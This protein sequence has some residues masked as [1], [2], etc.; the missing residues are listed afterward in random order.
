MLKHKNYKMFAAV[1][2]LIFLLITV[3]SFGK[4]NPG[5]GG[6]DSGTRNSFSGSRSGESHNVSGSF[7]SAPTRSDSMRGSSF[8]QGQSSNSQSSAF[9]R[10][11]SSISHQR[12]TSAPSRTFSSQNRQFSRDTNF[13]GSRDFHNRTSSNSS[14]SQTSRGTVSSP[15]LRPWQAAGTVKDSLRANNS[16]H[17]D[18]RRDFFA[19][20]GFR[21]NVR[22]FD[23]RHR[24]GHGFD[25]RHDFHH[26]HSFFSASILIGWPFFS[27]Y[28]WPYDNGYWPG[29]YGG[30]GYSPSNYQSSY[31]T[32]APSF[33]YP[34]RY[35]FVSLN[36]FWP[37][38]NYARYYDYGTYPYF[39]Y[40]TVSSP[41]KPGVAYPPTGSDY[42]NK[43]LYTYTQPFAYVSQ[44]E[45]KTAADYYFEQG[46]NAFAAGDYRKAVVNFYQ[47]KNS[48]PDDV[49]LPFAY[50]QAL[51]ADGNYSKAAQQLRA[52]LE[53]QPAGS[54]WAFYPRGLY[55][56]D[57][58]LISQIN[59]L[60]SQT[61]LDTNLQLLLGYQLL[62]IQKL[63]EAQG[64]LSNASQDKYNNVAAGKLLIVLDNLKTK[65]T[66]A[67]PNASQYYTALD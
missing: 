31:D 28:C 5:R 43:N 21:G 66:P 40:I 64:Y 19:R 53:K 65:T 48:S 13:N 3:S 8:H 63:D 58:I 27:D 34:R 42:D 46:V 29:Y 59:Q 61:S 11:T 18:N 36:G 2:L 44:P 37:G 7:R 26:R 38:Y 35:I 49:I 55:T 16:R 6:G 25:R 60:A 67:T 1:A 39:W 56:D 50:V 4:G 22:F 14:F 10:Q 20:D 17:F 41:Y 62:G 57:Q 45:D 52:A 30:Y 23:N 51:F 32:A 12:S 33:H 24:F 15:S 47:A 9:T 54:E